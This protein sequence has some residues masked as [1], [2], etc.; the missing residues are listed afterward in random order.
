MKYREKLGYM[1]LGGLIGIFGLAVGLCVSPLTAEKDTFGH[2]TCSG[3]KVVNSNGIA[4]VDLTLDGLDKDTG[5]IMVRDRNGAPRVWL[6]CLSVSGGRVGVSGE[7]GGAGLYCAEYGGAIEGYGKNDDGS[8]SNVRMFIDG[9]G[10]NVTV[11]RDYRRLVIMAEGKK[12]GFVQIAGTCSNPMVGA[13]LR[14]TEQGTKLDLVDAHPNG[15]SVAV[16]QASEL[17]GEMILRDRS[18]ELNLVSPRGFS[19]S[20]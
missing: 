5:L 6:S 16:L 3:L 7:K 20:R 13:G 14:C 15:G 1:I 8:T 4:V 10:G 12:G 18:G 17:G 19:H 11:E 2:I 9:F